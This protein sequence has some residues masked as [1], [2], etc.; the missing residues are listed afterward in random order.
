MGPE[1]SQ[2]PRQVQFCPGS[3]QKATFSA[4]TG[5]KTLKPKKESLFCKKEMAHNNWR[6]FDTP[7]VGSWRHLPDDL[8]LQRGPTIVILPDGRR[9]RVPAMTKRIVQ[10]P[11]NEHDA[12][13]GDD[14]DK[15]L[16]AMLQGKKA[17]ATPAVQAAAA[18]QRMRVVPAALHR[19]GP[20]RVVQPQVGDMPR[21]VVGGGGA[22]A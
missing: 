19:G 15:T 1:R 13:E 12:K 21:P 18:G 8:S 4:R 7:L 3:T 10:A 9:L 20:G 11:G 14:I 5:A 22:L 16:Q 6:F 2:S 17:P